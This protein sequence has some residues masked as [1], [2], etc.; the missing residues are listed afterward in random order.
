MSKSSLAGAAALLTAPLGAIVA[1][2]VSTTM[3]DDAA[4][5]VAAFTSHHGAMVGGAVL[6]G[7]SIVLLIAGAG[8][9]AIALAPRAGRM[10]VVGGVLAVLGSLPVVY[11]DGVHAAVAAVATSGG[12]DVADRIL[13]STGV[14]AVE[15]FSLIGDAGL[16]LLGIAA[17]R[18]G[19]GRWVAVAI[20][21][22]AFGEGAGFA[23]GTKA[24]IVAAF[25]VLFAGL[26]GAVRALLAPAPRAALRLDAQSA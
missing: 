17:A 23:T 20:V 25:V 4:D 9:L 10:A 5:Q 2:L 26:A 6:Q 15:P 13:S 1:V 14:T 22:G 18:A 3:S 7:I 11:D 16:A 21:A 19:A 12:I 24:L 8:W